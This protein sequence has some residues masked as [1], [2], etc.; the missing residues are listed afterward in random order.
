MHQ[1][2][3]FAAYFDRIGYLGS[4]DPTPN[5]LARIVAAHTQRIPFENLDS[6]LGIPVADLG[7]SALMEKLV[8]RR[9][10]GFCFEQNNLLRYALVEIGFD[11]MPLLGRV[12]WGDAGELGG[13]KTPLTHQVL[14]VR[15]PRDDTWYLVDVG[16]AGQTPPSALRLELGAVQPTSHEPYRLREYLSDGYLLETLIADTWRPIYTFADAPCAEVDLHVGSWY[17]S[18]H[19][20][21]GLVTGL[22]ASIVTG[23]A[24]YNLRGRRLSVHHHDSNPLRVDLGSAAEVIDALQGRFGIDLSAL[25]TA[26][27]D[28]RIGAVLDATWSQAG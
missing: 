2:V 23:D 21:Y 9:R 24:R 8:Q 1:K 20:Q 27:L 16:F 6:L 18:T 7:S 15:A 28:T 11:V 12:V 19:P 3:D 10:G 17:A 22:Y 14:K 4:I 25:D 26:Q 13:V 5:T